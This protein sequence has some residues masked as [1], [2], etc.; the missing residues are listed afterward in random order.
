VLVIEHVDLYTQKGQVPELDVD[1]F[2]NPG[3]AK[4]VRE[5]NDV[6][7]ISYL[8][9]IKHSIEAIEQTGM[10]AE[11]I[12]LRWLDRASIDWETIW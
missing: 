7:V 1:Y 9:M 11:L 10:D 4:V 12:D 5:G 3:N 8:N 6:T 2:I